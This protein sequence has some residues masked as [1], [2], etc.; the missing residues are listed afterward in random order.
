MCFCSL[1]LSRSLLPRLFSGRCKTSGVREP[2]KDGTR[3]EGARKDSPGAARSGSPN[4]R[5]CDCGRSAGCGRLKEQ[6][7]GS[8]DAA[9]L[10]FFLPP[11]RASSL[12]LYLPLFL[13]PLPAC[14]GL[15]APAGAGVPL[16]GLAGSVSRQ[17]LVL[18]RGRCCL[19][20]GFPLPCLSHV[21]FSGARQKS[22]V[23][24]FADL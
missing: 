18:F 3:T 9:S 12:P 11:S 10:P 4:A 8:H 20:S 15:G 6:G 13:S 7:S 19:L 21:S 14:A 5:S 16:P 1:L 24:S 17:G 22:P 23:D 2:G